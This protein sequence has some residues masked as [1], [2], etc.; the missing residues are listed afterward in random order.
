MINVTLSTGTVPYVLN[1]A[2]V[3][4]FLKK[5]Y[6]DPNILKNCRPASNLPFVSKLME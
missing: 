4:R 2:I 1:K 3:K 6:L 5:A